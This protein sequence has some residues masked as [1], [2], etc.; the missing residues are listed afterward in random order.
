MKQKPLTENERHLLVAYRMQRAK[1]TLAE[2][3]NLILV[4]NKL[5][6]SRWNRNSVVSE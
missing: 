5:V 1:E 4:I 2:A 6:I 3:D